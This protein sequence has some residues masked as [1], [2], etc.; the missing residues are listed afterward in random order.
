VTP[1]SD[2]SAPDGTQ[3]VRRAINVL[4]VLARTGELTAAELA[5]E[6][7]LSPA[8]ASRMAKVLL[9][10]GMVRR[11]PVN[12][13][14]HLGAR[15]ALLG[16]AAQ[17]VLGLD[18]ALPPMRALREQTGESV[19]LAIRDDAESV[20][21]LRVQS[22]L[23]LRFEQTVGARF[24]LYSTASGKAML[25]FSGTCQAYLDQL[26]STLESVT[27]GTI[28]TRAKLRVDLKSTKERG[29]AVDHEENVEGVRCVGAPIL[30]EDG[31]SVA[32]LVVQAPS[33]R[34]DLARITQLGPVVIQVARELAHVI[35]DYS[36]LRY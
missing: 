13:A 25:S 5:R 19:N 10:E 14:Y 16:Q 23:P 8:T 29:Y 18:K 4:R 34:M 11:N 9:T 27:T 12:G 28:R 30:D 21:L 24:P 15:A 22:K 6:T 26:P 31:R 32:A 7:G 1:T 17:E 3:A 20:V 2:S 36:T 35:P 33:V